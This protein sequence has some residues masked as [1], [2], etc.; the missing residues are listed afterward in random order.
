MS[1]SSTSTDS[2]SAEGHATSS[3]ESHSSAEEDEDENENEEY[4]ANMENPDTLVRFIL[5]LLLD[6][7]LMSQFHLVTQVDSNVILSLL[8]NAKKE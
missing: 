7:Y 3:S 8:L 1:G 2:D 5:Y 4:M 6:S